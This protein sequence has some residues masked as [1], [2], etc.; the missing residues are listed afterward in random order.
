M[1]V[2]PFPN[3]HDVGVFPERRTL[4]AWSCHPSE[5][6]NMQKAG[7]TLA[8]K[9]PGFDTIIVNGASVELTAMLFVKG[10]YGIK[11]MPAV[12]HPMPG[13]TNADSA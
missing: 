4:V 7:W 9:V 11:E 2:K 10:P 5:Q 1:P 3:P 6:E 13:E 12:L 8:A